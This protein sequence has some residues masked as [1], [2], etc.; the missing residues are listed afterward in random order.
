MNQENALEKQYLRYTAF[1]Y[2]HKYRFGK[3]EFKMNGMVLGLFYFWWVLKEILQKM[4]IN[5]AK[6]VC[7][8][9]TVTTWKC[10]PLFHCGVLLKFVGKSQ[11]GLKLFND[12][13]LGRRSTCTSKILER[14]LLNA[15][16]FCGEKHFDR[17]CTEDGIA[18]FV[19]NIAL[20]NL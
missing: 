5:F 8:P 19:T 9:P 12:G 18:H 1:K 11:F 2:L 16:F 7:L 14:N 3:R 6:F 10:R 20:C 13:H 4:R 15:I 17:S